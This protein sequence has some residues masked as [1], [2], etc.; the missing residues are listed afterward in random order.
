MAFAGAAKRSE[1]TM[2]N[3]VPIVAIRQRTTLDLDST[4]TPRRLCDITSRRTQR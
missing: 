1:A 2:A 3:V 4:A